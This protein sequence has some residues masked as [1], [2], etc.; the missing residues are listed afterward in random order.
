M[1]VWNHIIIEGYCMYEHI[2]KKK[3]T[4]YTIKN[5]NTLKKGKKTIRKNDNYISPKERPPWC[6]SQNKKRVP[7]YRCLFY[8]NRCKFFAFTNAEKSDYKH[9]N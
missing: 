1:S 3:H 6:K 7:Q 5:I 2:S 9:L 4:Y 8:K